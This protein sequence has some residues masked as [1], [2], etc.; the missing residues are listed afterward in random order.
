MSEL[1]IL[2]ADMGK[3]YENSPTWA[4]EQIPELIK[5]IKT[6]QQRITELEAQNATGTEQFK[7]VNE[8]REAL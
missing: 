2:L 6:L 7:A 3:F 5:S 1:S 8:E 4:Y